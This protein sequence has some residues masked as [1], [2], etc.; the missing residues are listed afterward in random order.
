MFLLMWFA[1][2]MIVFSLLLLCLVYL[3]VQLPRNKL[4]DFGITMKQIPTIKK[5]NKLKI[6]KIKKINKKKG[7]TLQGAVLKQHFLM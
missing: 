3:A 1:K 6:K 5:N 4:F 7:K 2:H